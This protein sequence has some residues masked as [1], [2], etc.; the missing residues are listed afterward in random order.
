LH[1]WK[2]TIATILGIRVGNDALNAIVPVAILAPP[3]HLFALLSV[4]FDPYHAP[5]G[6]IPDSGNEAI[7]NHFFFAGSPTKEIMCFSP[8][9]YADY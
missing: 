5:Q 3:A 7:L 4:S 9:L 1:P 6:A 8:N 2:I